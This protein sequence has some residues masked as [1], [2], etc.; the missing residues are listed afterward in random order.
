MDTLNDLATLERE[1]A[2]RIASAGDET[3]LEAARV[4]ALGKK[5]AVSERLKGLGTMSPD[6]R[7][8]MG[9]ALNGLKDRITAAIA[10][11]RAALKEIELGRRLTEERVDVTLPLRPSPLE[12]G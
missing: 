3:A 12:T 7:Q 1:L 9:P 4:A 2:T 11:R 5:G 8:V 10:D 6:Q